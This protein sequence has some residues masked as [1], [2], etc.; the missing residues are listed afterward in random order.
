MKVIKVPQGS[1]EWL[2]IRKGKAMGTV[3]KDIITKRGNTKKVGFYQLI[4]DRVAVE[5]DG[6]E[7]AMERGHRLEADA[8]KAYE[9]HHKFKVETDL[10]IWVS[11]DDDNIAISPDGMVIGKNIAVEVKCLSSARHLQALIEQKVPSEYV[12]QVL[13]YFVVN[14]K[15][16][17]VDVVFYDPRIISRPL[18]VIRVYR[19]D[20]EKEIK[21]NAEEQKKLLEEVDVWVERLSF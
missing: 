11:D 13:Q 16:D 6:D 1:K 21:F 9:S 8:I 5:P 19:K 15:L 2:D 18:H 20:V 4:A 17:A 10:G 3:V 7:D 12:D 14:E